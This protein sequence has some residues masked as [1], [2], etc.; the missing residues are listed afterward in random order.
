MA[1]IMIHGMKPNPCAWIASLRTTLMERPTP[2]F[3]RA[4]A[5]A[6]A[7][8]ADLAV[9]DRDAAQATAPRRGAGPR[10]RRLR[11]VHLVSLDRVGA[12][13]EGRTL[14][15]DASFA[16]AKTDSSSGRRLPSTRISP[17]A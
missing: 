12:S 5:D 17:C 14:F 13:V 10:G 9:D 1:N 7:Q 15:A 16:I 8:L 6:R 3:Y 2:C 4:P 11:G